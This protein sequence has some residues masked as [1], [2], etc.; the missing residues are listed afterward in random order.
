MS[1][2]DPS[3]PAFPMAR[4]PFSPP[5]EY[6]KLRDEAPVSQVTMPDGG[7]AWLFTR[8]ADVKAVLSDNR[9]STDSSKPGFPI[10]SPVRK[11]QLQSETP[12]AFIRLD[13][14]DHTK[15]R[16]MLTKDFMVSHIEAMRPKIERIVNELLDRMEAKGPPCNFYEDVALAL[17]TVIISD[18]LGVP[19]EDRVF[20]QERSKDRLN[21]AGDPAAS[22]KATQELRE[23][24]GKLYDEKLKDL[25][26]RDDLISRLISSQVLPGHMTRAEAIANIDLLLLAGH[27]TTSNQISLGVLS[28][29]LHPDQKE[30]LV[31]D[32]S[33]VKSVVEESLRFHTILHFQGVRVAVEDVEVGGHLIRKGEG[34]LALLN[35]ANRDPSVFS[36]PDEF[37]IHRDGIRQHVAFG[38]GVHQCL[39]QPL[40]RVELQTIFTALFQ[41]FPSLSLAVPV[42]KLEFNQGA[43]VYGVKSLPLTWTPKTPKPKRFFSVDVS[44]C[45]GGGQCVVAAPK[46]FSQSED[47]GLVQI[48]D[49]NPPPS[50]YEAIREAAR[51]CPVLCIHVDK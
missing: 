39:G 18:I 29:L 50:E 8:H 25:G 51:L 10:L 13:P 40:A 17:P 38:F 32:S 31:K 37:N 4:C 28:L 15:F 48:L 33:L 20:F 36:S 7:K 9:F 44:K 30:A 12:K 23:F 35:A 27:E 14:P 42:E 43:A 26:N 6:A 22:V 21:Y 47:D 5:P 49:D 41:R 16:R 2:N 19:Y 24:I 45:V 1:T 11:A 46:I 34:V 3:A